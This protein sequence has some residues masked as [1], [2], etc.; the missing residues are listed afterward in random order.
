MKRTSRRFHGSYLGLRWK[1]S[2]VVG[3]SRTSSVAQW[4]MFEDLYFSSG[5]ASSEETCEPRFYVG[6][7]HDASVRPM[8]VILNPC[9]ETA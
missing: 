6:A 9:G 7:G 4:G 3:Q 1:E 2:I 8:P 5:N